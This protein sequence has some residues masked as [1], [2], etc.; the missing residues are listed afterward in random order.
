[1]VGGSDIEC[2]C[3]LCH[4]PLH[5]KHGPVEWRLTIHFPGPYPEP[6]DETMLLCAPCY[7]DWRD[8]AAEKYAVAGRSHRI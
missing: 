6:G 1:M 7:A 2:E 4:L 3:M 8:K 5:V